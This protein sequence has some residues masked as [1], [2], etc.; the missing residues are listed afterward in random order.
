MIAADIT[1]RDAPSIFSEV[2]LAW[3]VDRCLEVGNHLIQ[4]ESGNWF[5][6]NRATARISPNDNTELIYAEIDLGEGQV[7]IA[8][9]RENHF[10]VIRDTSNRSWYRMAYA[11]MGEPSNLILDIYDVSN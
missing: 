5:S 3:P 6:G 10:F 8:E 7:K 1:D 11:S 2:S 9:R 4:I